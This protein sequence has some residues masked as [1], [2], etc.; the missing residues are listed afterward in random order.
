[1]F[2]HDTVNLVVSH[3]FVSGGTA[4]DSERPI[5]LGGAYSVQTD[6][7]AVGAHYTA[8]GHLHRAQALGQ[9]S[10][11]VH[12]SGSPLAY[13]FSEAGQSKSINIVEI[14][15]KQSVTVRRIP[16]SCGMPL[17]RWTCLHGVQ[18]AISRLEALAGRQVW[19]DLD[20]HS[21]RYLTASELSQLRLAHSGIVN[22]RCTLTGTAQVTEVQ[23]LSDLSLPEMFARFYR[24][25][26]Q[27]TE[28]ATDLVRLF[29]ELADRVVTGEA[30]DSK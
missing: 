3:L 22:I 25:R 30:G 24:H 16:L 10:G 13:S 6:D 18:E 20:V 29:T 4:S 23:S 1:V 17:E 14:K 28:P 2:R 21:P 7:I 15:P 5:E 19:L 26:R 8:L 9:G 11:L 27:G 12:Y